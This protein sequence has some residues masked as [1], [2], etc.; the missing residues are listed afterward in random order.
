MMTF[1]CC[2]GFL[3]KNALKQVFLFVV[4]FYLNYLI[5]NSIVDVQSPFVAL[6]KYIG[7]LVSCVTRV[8]GISGL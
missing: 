2:R 4:V 3:K 6:P 1:I 7:V 8:G 5:N